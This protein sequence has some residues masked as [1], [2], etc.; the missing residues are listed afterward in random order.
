MVFRSGTV[1]TLWATVA[2]AS[3]SLA[4]GCSALPSMDD[5][6]PAEAADEVAIDDTAIVT[7]STEL[8]AS[9]TLPSVHD[10]IAQDRFVALDVALELSGLDSVLDGLEDFVLFAPIG[11]AFASSGADIGIEYSTLMNDHRLLEAIMRYHIVADPSTNQ[12]WRTLNGAS[13]D[14]D[15]TGAGTIERVDGVD[16]LDTIPVLNGTV[17][18]M[19]RLLLPAPEPL[20]AS[21]EVR[22][23][24]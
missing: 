17:V 5:S 20:V 3:I 21:T 13:L 11:G 22:T 15:R 23:T 12:S 9:P 6:S 18:V 14:V 19:P 8:A 10:V 4:T 2:F 24:G 1:K 7:G 16:V